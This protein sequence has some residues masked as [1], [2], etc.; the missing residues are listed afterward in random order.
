MWFGGGKEVLRGEFGIG[1]WVLRTWLMG[2]CSRL[3]CWFRYF[4]YQV[5]IAGGMRS[6]VGRYGAE[7]HG[8][9]KSYLD[10]F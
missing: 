2:V 5:G 8:A 3:K 6:L 9:S 7:V 4:M 1:F 10:Q